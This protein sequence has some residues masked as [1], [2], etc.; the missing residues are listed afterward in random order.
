MQ[1]KES[2]MVFRCELKIPSFGINDRH[3]STSLMMSNIYPHLTTIKDSYILRCLIWAY[4]DCQGPLTIIKLE[5]N[6]RTS[7]LT[8]ISCISIQ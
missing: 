5:I 7:D 8:T 6:L 1:E 4:S 3:L 2:I